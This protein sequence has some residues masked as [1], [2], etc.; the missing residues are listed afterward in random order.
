VKG[1]RYSKGAAL[2]SL[3]AVLTAFGL[4][5][6]YGASVAPSGMLGLTAAAGLLPAAAVV[7]G[8]ISAGVFC[9]AATGL[10]ALIL[11]P[12]KGCAILYLSFFGL[13]PLFKHW[14]EKL[15]KL[16]LEWLCKLAAFNAVLAV[17]WLTFKTLLLSQLPA[18]FEN[19]WA[20]CFVGNLAFVLYDLGFSKLICLYLARIHRAIFKE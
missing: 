9:Y 5:G 15:K 3:D 7:S 12:D 8:G 2:I 16:P 11:V 18:V 1:S 4:I 6:L 20:F 19:L 17:Y 14:V 10:L 13:Y